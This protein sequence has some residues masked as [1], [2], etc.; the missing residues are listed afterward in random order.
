M[1]PGVLVTVGLIVFSCGL[2]V[3]LAFR[4]N[5]GSLFGAGA[6]LTNFSAILT[7]PLYAAV[8][9]RSVVIAGLVTLGTVITAYPV[10]YYL[11]FHAGHRRP[12]ILFLVTLPPCHSGPVIFSAFS[13]GKSCWPTMAF[14]TRS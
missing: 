6:T 1:A 10:A 2:L 3:L 7:D 8:I 13:P 11:S 14:G 5:D 4:V 12:L 9:L